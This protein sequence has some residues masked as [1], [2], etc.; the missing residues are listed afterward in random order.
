MER[1]T[2]LAT[3]A[4]SV[5]ATAGCLSSEEEPQ[6]T[7]EVPN[8]EI[9]TA[10]LAPNPVDVSERDV[11]VDEFQT[12]EVNEET[13]TMVPVS[14]AH[15]WY[16]THKARFI[17]ARSEQEYAEGRIEGALYSPNP[18]GDPD[19]KLDVIPKD[20][21]LLVYCRTNNRAGT[22]ASTLLDAG[23]TGVYVLESGF[24]SWAS[25]GYQTEQSSR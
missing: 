23:R 6:L 15:Y 16:N 7:G 9:T 2:L 11:P 12:K 17:D 25:E 18:T 1:R 4:G 3:I 8:E 14:V 19:D 13:V 24:D 10:G 21:R 20:E 5:A 22:R